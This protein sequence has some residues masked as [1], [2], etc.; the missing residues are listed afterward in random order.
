M[1]LQIKRL[2]YDSRKF[3]EKN[4]FHSCFF[5]LMVCSKSY[6]FIQRCFNISALD[7]VRIQITKRKIT[8]VQF[9]RQP[10]DY[11][12]API[13]EIQYVSKCRVEAYNFVFFIYQNSVIS[14]NAIS[15]IRMFICFCFAIVSKAI[16]L[17]PIEWRDMA[18]FNWWYRDEIPNNARKQCKKNPHIHTNHECN[19]TIR[20]KIEQ[21]KSRIKY[22]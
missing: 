10:I 5:K 21:K 7:S 20:K 1:I 4:Y 8:F 12:F 22:W 16:T 2:R 19:G 14:N 9:N 17:M 13:Y 3:T 15:L 11:T 6:N 18:K